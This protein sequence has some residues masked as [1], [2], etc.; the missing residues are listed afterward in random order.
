MEVRIGYVSI[1]L[2]IFN[3]TPSST[4]TYKLFQQRPYD[5]AM[6]RAIAVGRKNLIATQRILYFNAAHGIKLHRLSS[7]LVPLA[8]HPDVGID[9]R[10]TYA[11]E[12]KALGDF[13]KQHDMRL[14]M[15]PN[16]FTL[17]NG[18]DHV[19]A[20]ALKDLAYH[21][22]LLDGMGLD[23]QHKVNIHIGGAYGDKAKAVQKLYENFPQVPDNVRK[24]LTFENDDKTY[25]VTETL[26]ACEKIGQPMMLDIHHDWCNP[27][28]STPIELLPR[29]HA[30]WGHTPMKIHVSSP[31]DVSDFRAHS[32]FID[33]ER[34]LMF[35]K[36]CKAAGLPRIDVM[37]EAKQ[38]DFACLKLAAD[39]GKVRGIKRVDG[40]VL[41][42]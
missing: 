33:P 30:T 35:L 5:E 9:V 17:L 25:T 29:I 6:A 3:N 4:F 12:L 23:E 42:M 40:A 38:K 7:S 27:S 22:D 39:L 28:D 41:E 2:A 31:K 11:E 14:T 32:E 16:Q 19:T 13:A 8:T 21:T 36:A 24:R 10:A 26:A 37:V 34:L 20:A 18:A 15:H 1:A